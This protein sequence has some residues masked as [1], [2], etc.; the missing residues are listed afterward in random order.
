M[1]PRTIEIRSLSELRAV[2]GPWDDLWQRSDATL[3][4]GRVELIAQWIEAN[5][6]RSKFR[7][8]AVEQDS[9]IV[10]ALPL[11]SGKIKR[12]VPVARLPRNDWS[13]AGDLL[14]DPAADDAVLEAL[15]GPMARAGRP[16]VWFDAV[17][18]KAPAWQRLAAA[19][20]AAGLSLHARESFRVGRIDIDHD[21]SAY[22]RSWTKNHRRQMKRVERVAEE[23]GGATL[24]VHRRIEPH[25]LELLLRRGF[26]VEDASW[27][28]R[29]G[30]SVLK[31][32]V[33]LAHYIEQAQ[34]IATWG[35]VQLTFL[36]LAGRP[37][38]FEYGWN[39][40]G[41]YHS[42]KVGYDEAYAKLSPGQLLRYRLL[43]QFFADPKQRAVDFIGPI[44]AATEHWAT[45]TYPVGRLAIAHSPAGRLLVHAYRAWRPNKATPPA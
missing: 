12:V 29:A 17:P 35:D 3:P 11:V 44:V 41:V 5:A 13:W 40:K 38:A 23:E 28:G 31:T 14:L 7:A 1:L 16:V 18:L 27:K 25:D 34:Q 45:S 33:A 43:R 6:P 22:E 20:R 39:C 37:I 9:R 42:F 26:A 4:L 36:E 2:A 10:A 21:W 24:V 30:S 15:I 32:P 19:T 8:I